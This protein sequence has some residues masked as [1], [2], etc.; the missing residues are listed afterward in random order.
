MDWQPTLIGLGAVLAGA[1]SFLSGWAALRLAKKKGIE[2]AEHEA[3][4][5]SGDVD[6]G[7]REPRGDSGGGGGGSGGAERERSAGPRDDGDDQP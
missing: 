2:E 4:E 3:A 5:Q 7:E 1:G 6:G